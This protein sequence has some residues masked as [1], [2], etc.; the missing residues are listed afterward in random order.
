MK[1][2]T[3]H[4]VWVALWGPQPGCISCASCEQV[5]HETDRILQCSGR[6]NVPKMQSE[7]T[8]MLQLHSMQST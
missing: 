6:A 2:I 5:V 4:Q 3:L 1:S 7:A 8:Y